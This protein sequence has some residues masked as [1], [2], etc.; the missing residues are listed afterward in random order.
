MVVL[1][2]LQN[3][4]DRGTL[5]AGSRFNPAIWR[6]E[7]YGT[8][9]WTR[10]QRI[11]KKSECQLH[12]TNAAPGIGKGARSSLPISQKNVRDAIR[13]TNPDVIIACGKSAEETCVDWKGSLIVLPHPAYMVLTNRLLDRAGKLLRKLPIRAALRQGQG[14]IN[15]E[16]I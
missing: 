3:A 16:E 8:R 12:F 13:R 9:T 7:F 4:Y 15:I 10:L 2:V 5:K 14:F 1:V 11:F 6:S